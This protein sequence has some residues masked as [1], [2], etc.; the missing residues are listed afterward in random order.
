MLT[1]R[2][3]SSFKLFKFGLFASILFSF[4]TISSLCVALE[5][6]PVHNALPI[7]D[8]PVSNE[9]EFSISK[10]F[11]AGSTEDWE[12]DGLSI[13]DEESVFSVSLTYVGD[14]ENDFQ[15]RMGQGG[16][17]YSLITPIDELIGRQ[18]TF[19]SS[20]SRWNDAV[21]ESVVTNTN[22]PRVTGSE[23]NYTAS[24]NSDMNQGGTYIRDSLNKPFYSPMLRYQALDSSTIRSIHW[25]PISALPTNYESGIL[26]DQRTRNM[27]KGVIEVTQLITNFGPDQLENRMAVPWTEFSGEALDSYGYGDSNGNFVE[28]AHRNWSGADSTLSYKDTAGWVMFID[29]D[30]ESKIGIS[31]ITGGEKYAYGGDEKIWR[32]S[33][34]RFGDLNRTLWPEDTEYIFSGRRSINLYVGETVFFRYYI[35]FGPKSELISLS[36]IYTEYADYG[37][38]A[39]TEETAEAA[40][41]NHLCIVDGRYSTQDCTDENTTETDLLLY[42]YHVPGSVPVFVLYNTIGGSYVYTSDPYSIS[43]YDNGKPGRFYNGVTEYVELLGWIISKDAMT[44]DIS[45]YS[46]VV[47]D[48]KVSGD[49]DNLNGYWFRKIKSE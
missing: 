25:T 9:G 18:H 12:K 3:F 38:I 1:I 10:K 8:A 14:G 27:G 22:D 43:R 19:P 49:F 47:S 24:K 41:L 40:G 45:N 26:Y 36:N 7:S 4:S 16:Q 30:N 21:L 48:P 42:D 44:L 6:L 37:Q 5:S 17:F 15:M 46:E 28:L 32:S 31:L 20:Y 13:E 23:A 34:Y 39:Y 11:I 33:N 35:A 29:D 2:F